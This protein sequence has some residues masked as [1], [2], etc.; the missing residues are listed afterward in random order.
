[1]RT[2]CWPRLI[3]GEGDKQ[4]I[5]AKAVYARLKEIGNDLLHADE[6]AA[7]ERYADLLKQQSVAKAK[8]KTAQ[9]DLDEK[10][11]AKYPRLTE[12]EIKTLVV[13]DKWMARLS[14]SVQGEVDRVSQTPTSRIH[15]LAQR[16]ATPLSKLSQE[17]EAL[18][19]RVEEHLTK[20]G[21]VWT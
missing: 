15:E 16:Y 8:R 18:A 17:L 14:T 2:G 4:K 5:T 6:R 11:G 20:M 9:E 13:D 10:I 21:A 1:M 7:L 3:E 19:A 12:A